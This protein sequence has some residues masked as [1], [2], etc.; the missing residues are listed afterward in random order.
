M[1]DEN[2]NTEETYGDGKQHEMILRRQRVFIQ[3]LL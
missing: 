1:S 3:A 2:R